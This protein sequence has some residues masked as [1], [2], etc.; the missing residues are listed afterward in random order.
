MFFDVCRVTCFRIVDAVERVKDFEDAV[1]SVQVTCF[2]SIAKT[3]LLRCDQN[4]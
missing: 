4:C 1:D 2:P 3:D